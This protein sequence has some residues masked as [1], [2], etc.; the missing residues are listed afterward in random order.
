MQFQNFFRKHEFALFL[1]LT[2]TLSWWS[3]PFA[4]GGIIP[5]GPALAA[6]IVI[7]LISGRQGFAEYVTRLTKFNAGWWYLVGP[8]IVVTYLII[9]FVT[10]LLLGAS[11]VN[12]FPIPFARKPILLFLMGGLWEELGWTGYALPKLQDHF[13]SRPHGT[14]VATLILGFFRALWHMPL[15]IYGSIEW[16]DATFF[17][18]AFQLIITWLYNKSNGSV[19]AVMV[20][21]YASNVLTGSMMLI[22]FSGREKTMYYLLF[23]FFACL[24]ALYLAWQTKL[25][26]GFSSPD[27]LRK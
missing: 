3:A 1:V 27:F 10:N 25:Q 7:A 9:A 17:I 11:T 19:P 15:V 14:F 2:Y 6:V 12:P 16:Y 13:A 20:F 18:F 26:L 24:T 21:H 4:I 22:A 23:V 5:H 8:A